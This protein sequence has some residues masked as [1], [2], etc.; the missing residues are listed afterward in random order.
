MNRFAVLLLEDDPSTAELLGEFLRSLGHE[1]LATDSLAMVPLSF[2]P[3][4]VVTDLVT[5]RSYSYTAAAEAVAGLRTR[6]GGV[7]IVLLTAHAAAVTDRERLDVDEV[8]AKPFDLED[9]VGALDRVATKA[10]A[11]LGQQ[12]SERLV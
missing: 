8:V 11:Q 2:R 9:L 1:V 12:R 6:F 7:P 5:M 4:V 3:T 10:S